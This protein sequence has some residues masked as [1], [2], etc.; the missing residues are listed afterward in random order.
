MQKKKKNGFTLI[1]LLVVIAIIALLLSILTPA[2]NAVKERARRILCLSALRQ[3]GIAI[4]AYN[5]ANDNLMFTIRRY[6]GMAFPH[7]TAALP[8]RFYGTSVATEDMK[9]GEFSVYGINPYIDVVDKNFEENGVASEIICCPNCSG[10]FMVDWAY[11]GWIAHCRPPNLPGSRDSPSQYFLEPA[12]S[13]WV[14]GGMDPPID[15]GN[16]SSANVLRD[17]TIDTLSPKRLL[18]SEVLCM[19]YDYGGA[20]FRYNHGRD[21]WA[22]CLAWADIQ[23]PPGHVKLDGEQDA[24][25]R[26]QLFGDGHV[27][28]RDISLKFEDNIPSEKYGV[29]FD[30]EEWNG[31]GSGWIVPGILYSWY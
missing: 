22:W 7:F 10:D 27:Q 29:G 11:V 21:G 20:G 17:L 30:E 6:D 18:M 1:E 31:P 9:H 3:W 16:E 19:D 23:A 2:L 15:V 8:P 28:W 5:A 12:Y 26:S 14:L 25:G 24:T 13:Y 4:S